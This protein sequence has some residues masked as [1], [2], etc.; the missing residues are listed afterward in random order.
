[1]VT[2]TVGATSGNIINGGYSAF[3]GEFIY[4][5]NSSAGSNIYKERPDGSGNSKVSDISGFGINV[6]GDWV[7][8]I[9]GFNNSG[10]Y[11]VKKDGSHKTKI[12]SDKVESLHIVNEWVYYSVYSGDS[13]GV[14]KIKI[15]GSNKTKISFGDSKLYLW[16][17]PEFAIE[18]G[19]IYIN[20]FN[21]D[22]HTTQFWRVKIDGSAANKL[23][24]YSSDH[25][26]ISNGW[27]YFINKEYSEIHKMKVDGSN[28]ILIYK[29]SDY[30]IYSINTAGNNIYYSTD[31]QSSDI[32]Y[33]GIYKIN[34]D[35][36]GLKRLTNTWCKHFTISGGWI[37]YDDGDKVKA[38]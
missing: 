35:G 9:G 12:S 37:Y 26:S 7:Y 23:L 29:V 5:V 11:K 30:Y 17:N 15:D 34:M 25:F 8:F 38:D 27:I 36:S 18:N 3:D 22:A 13:S 19:W 33:G 20:L 10:I 24:D 6:V 14:Y 16:D 1:V 21:P 31:N 4:Y 32:K 2:N 28:N